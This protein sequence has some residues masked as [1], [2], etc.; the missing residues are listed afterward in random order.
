MSSSIAELVNND[1]KE[2]RGERDDLNV[3]NVLTTCGIVFGLV[4][5]YGYI[6]YTLSFGI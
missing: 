1:V 6:I 5:V 4:W 3:C 2:I